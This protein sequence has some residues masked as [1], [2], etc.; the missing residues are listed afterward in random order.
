MQHIEQ[1]MQKGERME[2]ISVK[3][4]LPNNGEYVLCYFENAP[5][6]SSDIRYKLRV[7]RFRKGISMAER[8]QMKA[9]ITDDHDVVY[10]N[11][12]DGRYVT[13]RSKVYSAEDEQN[14][15]SYGYIWDIHGNTYAAYYVT[16]WCRIDISG[17]V[18]R[19]GTNEQ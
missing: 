3:D 4:E 16:R 5:W 19:S 7:A 14:S 12:I 11:G 1:M 9:G 15:N 17:L 6:I 18:S 8:Q 13:K 2:W 10:S